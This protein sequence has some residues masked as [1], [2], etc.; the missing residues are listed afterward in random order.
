MEDSCGAIKD[1]RF[2]METPFLKVKDAAELLGM[3][4]WTVRDLIRRGIIP[5]YK[6]TRHIVILRDELEKAVKAAR[7]N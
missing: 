1:T 3:S 5:G 7:V 6:I 4:P 2:T